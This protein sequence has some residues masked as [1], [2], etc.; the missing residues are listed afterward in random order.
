VGS[1]GLLKVV[2]ILIGALIAGEALALMI[3]MHVL[4]TDPHPWIS[5]KNDALAISDIIIG[6]GLIG[7][8]LMAGSA[9]A[10]PFYSLSA[11]AVL[12]HLYRGG[13]YLVGIRSA[14]CF[15]A[16]LFIVNNVK[17][18]GALVILLVVLLMRSR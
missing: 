6:L 1:T 10:I 8:G 4:N 14:F 7:I 12:T 11:L 2:S 16:P 3:G 9:S 17:L 18:V 5:L 15:N 13:E